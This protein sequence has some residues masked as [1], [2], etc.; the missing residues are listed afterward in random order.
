[1]DNIQGKTINMKTLKQKL[2]H[3]IKMMIILEGKYPFNKKKIVELLIL[4]YKL[5][6]QDLSHIIKINMA[7]QGSQILGI[8]P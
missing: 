4:I 2:L 1:M 7:I 8:R 3:S 6:S 5:I